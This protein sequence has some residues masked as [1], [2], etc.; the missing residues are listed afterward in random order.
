MKRFRPY[1]TNASGSTT[2]PEVDR[3]VRSAYRTESLGMIPVSGCW[4]TGEHNLAVLSHREI[5][6]LLGMTSCG[7]KQVE[8]RALRKLRKAFRREIT[9]WLTETDQLPE[10]TPPRVHVPSLEERYTVVESAPVAQPS[11]F[12]L[13]WEI[14]CRWD[15]QQQLLAVDSK[16]SAL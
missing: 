12:D 7:V 5:G 15:D 11:S 2:G 6:H 1:S 10:S 16:P 8:Q 13:A 4:D 14:F 9:E 3:W